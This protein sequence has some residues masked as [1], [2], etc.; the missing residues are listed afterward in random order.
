MTE[1]P[2][3]YAQTKAQ[4]KPAF[5]ATKPTGATL[6]LRTFFPWQVWRFLWINF[7]MLII[8]HKSHKGL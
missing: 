6:F 1:Q 7:K 3:E 8:I 2:R 5:Y 4:M